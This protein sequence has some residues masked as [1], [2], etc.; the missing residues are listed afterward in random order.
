MYK[1]G[2]SCSGL[3]EEMDKREESNIE[4]EGCFGLRKPLK[5]ET[6]EEIWGKRVGRHLAWA[7]STPFT[8][9]VVIAG[10]DGR[11]DNNSGEELKMQTSEFLVKVVKGL[12]KA[13]R[14]YLFNFDMIRDGEEDGYLVINMNYFPRYEKLS[15]Y[16]TVMID[17]FLNV[18]KLQELEKMKKKEIDDRWKFG[19]QK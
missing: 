3:E 9:G 18:K 10:D 1:G 7:S 6:K 4:R 5:V 11:S 17:F 15:S 16:E 14:L 8:L 19:N 12:R 13:L 2:R